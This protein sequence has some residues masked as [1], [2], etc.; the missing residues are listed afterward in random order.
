MAVNEGF[1]KKIKAWRVF[2]ISHQGKVRQASIK[3]ARL[4]SLSD[5][6]HGKGREERYFEMLLFFTLP[7]YPLLAEKN[8]HNVAASEIRLY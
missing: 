3:A 1:K 2:N 5:A 8:L 6:G 7:C 4:P